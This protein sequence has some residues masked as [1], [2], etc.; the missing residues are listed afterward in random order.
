M[1]KFISIPVEGG[2]TT[3]AVIGAVTLT[4]G[5]ITAI[6]GTGVVTG[7]AYTIPPIVTVT[8][9]D[10]KG[11]GAV[12]VASTLS[13]GVPSFAII[14]GGSGYTSASTVICT[15]SPSSILINADSVLSIAPVATGSSTASNA[16]L[17]IKMNTASA[18]TLTLTLA[19]P[20]NAAAPFATGADSI[21]TKN[22]IINALMLATNVKIVEQVTPVILPSTVIVGQYAFA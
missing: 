15:V 11:S 12:I 8:S 19:N 9:T 20:L 2:T 14:S 21:A 1:G 22:A 16:T 10:G 3:T 13:G 18:P 4:S 7:V 17:V 5:V 6:G